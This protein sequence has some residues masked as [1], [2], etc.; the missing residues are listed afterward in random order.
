MST[1]ETLDI[2]GIAAGGDGV[3]RHDGL[4]VFVPRT[5]TGDRVSARVTSKGRFA[6]G[7]LERVETRGTGRVTPECAHYVRDQCG[8]CQLQ[9]LS[10]GAQRDAKAL[11]VRDAFAR[12]GKREVPLPEVRGAGEPWRYRRKLTLAL[13]WTGAGAGAG[14]GWRA[15]LHRAGAPDE[16]FALDDCLIADARI[17]AGF[18]EMLAQG[19]RFLPRVPALRVSLRLAGDELLLV[20]E[21]GTH[22]PSARAFADAVTGAAGIAACWWV[23]DEG[24]RR[25]VR[26]RPEHASPGA[27][28]V[29]VNE[30][31]AAA[32]GAHVHGLVMAH[33]P[34]TVVDGYAGSGDAAVMLA[35]Q[36][37]TVTAIELDAH[38]SAWS[39]SRLSAPSRAVSARVED[40][41]PGA[42]PADV[43]L[44]NPPRTGVAPEVTDLLAAC[45]PKPRAIIYVSCDPATLARD[46]AR[47]PGWRVASLTCFDM[48]PQ[49]A[50]VETVCE[51]VPEAA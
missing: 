23:N 1:I 33:A 3:A 12:I 2:T 36:G 10:V 19:A 43:V 4:V 32:M 47:L 29:Q 13:R 25:L 45:D 46:V 51:L 37:V 34:R 50:H 7:V 8:G 35:A 14:V 11:I 21:G 41:L 5:A 24:E 18:R 31:V 20:V 48:F 17:V 28:F 38:A 42:L 15:G 6:R 30:A 40:A 9:H 22:W 27:S 39:A 44:L 26:D 16:V 49:T